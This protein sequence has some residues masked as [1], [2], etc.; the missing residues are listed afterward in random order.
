MDRENQPPNKI[1]VVEDDQ[2]LSQVLSDKLTREGFNVVTAQNGEEG[3]ALAI[4]EKPALIL[5]DLAMPKMGGLAMMKQ[6][7]VNNEWG[8]KVPIII[9]TNLTADDQI[10]KDVVE[11]EPS[12]YLVKSDHTIAEVVEKVK[13]SLGDGHKNN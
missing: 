8:R 2:A 3:L 10:M 1:L 11:S 4:K 5:L 12:Y 9:L 7:R 6:L 13:E